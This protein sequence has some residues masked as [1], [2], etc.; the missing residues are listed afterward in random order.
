MTIT[1]QKGQKINLEKDG[2]RE[3][4]HVIVGLGWDVADDD[5]I[6][7]DAS[8]LLCGLDGKFT[9]ED[10]I[11][12]FYNLKHSSGS[13]KHTGDNLTGE[14]DG[15]DEQII[16]KLNAVPAK[17]GK[18][19]FAVNIYD[20]EGREQHFGMVENAFIRIVDSDTGKELAK[21]NLSENYDGMTAM[22][23]GEI[24]R[25]DG[26]WKFSA[27]GQATKDGSIEELAERFK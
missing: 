6:D 9:D 10:D 12:S 1:L 16:V 18:I 26:K 20:A 22:I 19:V 3:L 23:F 21:Y 7:C 25:K 24:Y 27:I 15:D 5:D 8:A 17:Y 2:G 4:R 13:V 11:V 14:G